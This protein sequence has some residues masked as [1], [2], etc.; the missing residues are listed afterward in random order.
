M[1]AVDCLVDFKMVEAINNKHKNK[2]DGGMKSKADGKRNGMAAVLESGENMKQTSKWVG[3]FICRGPHRAKDFPKREKVSALQLDNDSEI[4]NMET[5][6]NPIQMVNTILKSNSIFKLM[7]MVVQVNRIGVKALVDTGATH[8]CVA[9][10]VAASLGLEIEAY[11]SVVTSL[12]GKDHWVDGIIRS[13]PME[14]G[15]WVGCCD[16]VV[17]HLRDFEMIMGMNFLMRT[18]VS[19]M[20]YLRTLA[21][22]EKGTPC[23]VLPVE[24]QA[25]KTEDGMRL[26]SSTKHGGGWLENRD[27]GL[28]KPWQSLGSGQDQVVDDSM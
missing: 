21:F 23:T 28:W 17:M 6:L 24:N 26:Y 5:R 2:P 7:Y 9:S 14:M 27:N 22:M 1:A 3:C 4:G 16:L 8:T 18:E 15:D 12:N 13:C 11:D 19:I 20:P 25:M 10:D